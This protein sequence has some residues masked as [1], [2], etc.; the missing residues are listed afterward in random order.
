[1]KKI[2]AL[3]LALTMAFSMALSVSAKET[4]GPNQDT[5]TSEGVKVVI[6]IDGVHVLHKY[7]FDIVYG[8]ME[9]VYGESLE[10]DPNEYKYVSKGNAGDW[11]P[12]TG[13]ANKITVIN[14]SDLPIICEAKAK[15]TD[16]TNGN[17][18]LTVSDGDAKKI[19]GRPVGGGSGDY[20]HTMT[21]TLEGA[22]I[23]SYAKKQQIGS[24][25]VTITKDPTNNDTTVEEQQPTVE[26]TA[27]AQ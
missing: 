13:D 23:I 24:V 15:V 12:A 25:V 2:I 7:A 26:P 22:P 6:T 4:F 17:F 5:Y 10:W 8:S 14:H 21:V 11:N 18:T 9:F 16:T 1:M 27:N 3:V 20:D 19:E